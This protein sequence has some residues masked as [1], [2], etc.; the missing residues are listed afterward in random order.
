MVLP[1][2]TNFGLFKCVFVWRYLI[3]SSLIC[4]FGHDVNMCTLLTKGFFG[5]WIECVFLWRLP[6][7]FWRGTAQDI[8]CF[9]KR[10]Q[11]HFDFFLG[12]FCMVCLKMILNKEFA[13]KARVS[14]VVLKHV[15]FFKTRM[16]F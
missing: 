4:C 16:I 11:P 7:F 12:K 3:D 2:N 13:Y 10:I 8:S 15:D 1:S 5:I 14:S 9:R 6:N